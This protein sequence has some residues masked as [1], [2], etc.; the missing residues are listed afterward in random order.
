M[1][2]HNG[3]CFE[4]IPK[5]KNKVDLVIVDLPYGQTDCKWDEA[6][7]L[8][9]M[10]KQLKKICEKNCIY[11]FF[12]NTR[13]GASLINSNPKWFRYDIVWEK[14]SGT[15]FLHCRDQPIRMHEMI[16]IFKN[17]VKPKNKCFTYNPQMTEGKP[18]SATKDKGEY[19]ETPLYTTPRCP[20]KENK[21][22]RFPISIL[23]YKKDKNKLH[24]TQKPVDL[25]EWLV[26]SYSNEHDTVLDFTMGSGST[27]IA[28][29]NTE[30]YF[31]GIEKDEKIFKVASNRLNHHAVE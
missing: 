16:Y 22:T 14:N 21:G 7:D 18:Y 10:W 4:I 19:P 26:E 2:L 24:P 30:R 17:N 13:F 1:E 15:G 28:C 12:C 23:R 29:L 20:T 6:I 8:T 5:L 11:A 9:E 31:I 27:G 3:D 25:C